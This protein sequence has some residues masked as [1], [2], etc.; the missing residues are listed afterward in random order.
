MTA[1]DP[2]PTQTKLRSE[3]GSLDRESVRARL[4][5]FVAAQ[6]DQELTAA[7]VDCATSLLDDGILDSI[8]AVQLLVD[9]EETFGVAIDE[10]ELV[11]HLHNLDRLADFITAN[12]IGTD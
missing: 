8:G 11:G 6:S 4:R 3:S 7:Q 5:V 2:K 12:A 1:D 9:I 10:S